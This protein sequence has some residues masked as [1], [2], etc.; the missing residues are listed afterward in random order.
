MKLRTLGR[1]SKF[2]KSCSTYTVRTL[3]QLDFPTTHLQ[4]LNKYYQVYKVL[5]VGG[6]AFVCCMHGPKPKPNP[7]PSPKPQ[8]RSQRQTQPSKRGAHNVFPS[9]TRRGLLTLPCIAS[10][11]LTL[12]PSA[13][14]SAHP[15]SVRA[16][17]RQV[18][19]PRQQL[20][21]RHSP[22]RASRPR[23]SGAHLALALLALALRPGGR[24]L[25]LQLPTGSTVWTAA[26]GC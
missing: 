14:P 24:R 8:T 15:S 1:I 22:W 6:C 17:C 12:G 13:H 5:S 10:R 11:D 7:N 26:A 19:P 16:S 23:S 21:A 18:L 2:G 25:P 9:G 20:E 4:L 3:L